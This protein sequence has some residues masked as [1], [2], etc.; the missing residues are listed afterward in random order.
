[1]TSG[2]EVD[3]DVAAR[4]LGRL[5]AGSPLWLETSNLRARDGG[6]ASASEVIG[7][8]FLAR[9]WPSAAITLFI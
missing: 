5:Q 9:L 4:A 3:E 7:P 8:G 2:F 1:L 6:G